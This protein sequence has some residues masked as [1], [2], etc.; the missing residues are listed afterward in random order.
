MIWSAYLEQKNIKNN[1]IVEN[2][3]RLI[4]SNG[5][6]LYWGLLIIFVYLIE[7]VLINQI[8]LDLELYKTCSGGC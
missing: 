1:S 4:P 3:K 5:I 2:P 7:I 8:L 6:A